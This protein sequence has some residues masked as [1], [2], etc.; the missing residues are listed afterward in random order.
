MYFCYCLLVA[1]CCYF[2]AA[3]CTPGIRHSSTICL[4]WCS[5]LYRQ[6]ERTKDTGL[7][8]AVY[9]F[10]FYEVVTA[11]AALPYGGYQAQHDTCWWCAIIYEVYPTRTTSVIN[12]CYN[13]ATL[14][15]GLRE[16]KYQSTQQINHL[17][18]ENHPSWC[19]QKHLESPPPPNRPCF[20][21]STRPYLSTLV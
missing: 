8:T 12:E 7:L 17:V 21:P 2:I 15:C 19:T 4:L 11:V 5:R 1:V 3:A 18:A 14:A 13:P 6:Q 20:P 16:T 10:H 9:L